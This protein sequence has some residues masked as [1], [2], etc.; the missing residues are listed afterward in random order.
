MLFT[1][2]FWR[3]AADRAL[4]TFAQVLGSYFIVGTTGLVGLDWGTALSVAGGA[5]LASVLMSVYKPEAVLDPA[6][7]PAAT[8]GKHAAPTDGLGE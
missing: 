5:A 1:L 3:A 7:V 8:G 2:A 4:R 6:V